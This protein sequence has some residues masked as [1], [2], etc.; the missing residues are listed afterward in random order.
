M[1]TFFKHEGIFFDI[2]LV[3]YRYFDDYDG[4]Y[5]LEL[6]TIQEDSYNI[7]E[8]GTYVFSIEQERDE[9]EKEMLSKLKRIVMLDNE[10]ED[11]LCQ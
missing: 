1:E 8:F 6:S 4:T 3:V 11:M 2:N 10:L 7:S 5:C 9:F